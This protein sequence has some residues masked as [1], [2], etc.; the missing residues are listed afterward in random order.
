MLK[1][2]SNVRNEKL[3]E[4]AEFYPRGPAGFEKPF[5]VSSKK[6]DKYEVDNVPGAE[7]LLTGGREPVLKFEK[8]ATQV[9]KKQVTMGNT[10]QQSSKV[11]TMQDHV[12]STGKVTRTSKV[13]G[14]GENPASITTKQEPRSEIV[15]L[16]LQYYQ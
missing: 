16:L 3:K 10:G 12:S 14:I 1:R 9:L 15:E 2:I 7:I 4:T 6:G 8:S 5:L 13:H 11:W